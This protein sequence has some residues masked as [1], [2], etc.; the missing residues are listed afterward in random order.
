MAHSHTNPNACI[1]FEGSS[2]KWMG[3]P[4]G[5]STAHYKLSTN[6][7][8]SKT[9]SI[10]GSIRREEPSFKKDYVGT[11]IP[12]QITPQSCLC[13][14]FEHHPTTTALDLFSFSPFSSIEICSCGTSESLFEKFADR[15]CVTSRMFRGVSK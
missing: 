15:C 1:S 8:L 13:S 9:R 11:S 2:T 6:L 14:I 7:I 4:L 3:C 5:P 12:E 10:S